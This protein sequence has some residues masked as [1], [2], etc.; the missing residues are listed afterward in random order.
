MADLFLS[1]KAL[2][3]LSLSS[4]T[5]I[6]VYADLV[7]ERKT[8]SISLISLKSAKARKQLIILSMESSSIRVLTKCDCPT[9]M[10]ED[11]VNIASARN[12]LARSF[13]LGNS[14]NRITSFARV[15]DKMAAR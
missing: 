5:S 7:S 8:S 4:A 15:D 14:E 11:I 2:A 1:S 10:I 13:E 9:R 6:V 12:E 3:F